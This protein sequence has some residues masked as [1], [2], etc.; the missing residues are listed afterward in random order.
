MAD[1]SLTFAEL[2]NV[3]FKCNQLHLSLDG[4]D[5]L[6]THDSGNGKMRHGKDVVQL[7]FDPNHLDIT[8]SHAVV[9]IDLESQRRVIDKLISQDF[10]LLKDSPLM[11][12]KSVTINDFSVVLSS[13]GSLAVYFDILQVQGIL[14]TIQNV[15]LFVSEHKAQCPMECARGHSILD[16]STVGSMI[17]IEFFSMNTLENGNATIRIG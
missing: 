16:A 17:Y 8:V 7:L 2:K 15:K 10:L 4:M 11:S 12:S 14:L 13:G 6:K 9:F 3:S 1:A 5:V